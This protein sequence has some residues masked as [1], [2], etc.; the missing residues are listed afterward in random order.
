LSFG[1]FH[2]HWGLYV[3]SWG[4]VVMERGREEGGGAGVFVHVM[5]R[6]KTIIKKMYLRLEMHLSLRSTSVVVVVVFPL[7]PRRRPFRCLTVV[8]DCS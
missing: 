6:K 3:V 1:P 7:V 2:G 5:T 4:V 8:F